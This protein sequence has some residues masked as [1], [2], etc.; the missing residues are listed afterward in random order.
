MKI[1]NKLKN[2]GMATGLALLLGCESTY[3]TYKVNSY[4]NYNNSTPSNNK[5]QLLG[6]RMPNGDL[7]YEL[8]RIQDLQDRMKRSFATVIPD[9][10]DKI[11]KGIPT[12]DIHYLIEHPDGSANIIYYEE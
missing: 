3:Q 4:P 7:L 10:R 1:N 5:Y 2:I 12:L 11:E 9:L 8:P 6:K